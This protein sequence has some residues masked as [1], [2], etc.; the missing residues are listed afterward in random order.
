MSI[1]RAQEFLEREKGMYPDCAEAYKRFEEL[2]QQKLWHQLSVAIG[3]HLRE[4]PRRATHHAGR[5]LDLY[6][7]FVSEFAEKLNPL[8]YVEFAVASVRDMDL[9]E[10]GAVDLALKYLRE[11]V[12]HVKSRSEPDAL[13]ATAVAVAVSGDVCVAGGRLGEARAF[14]DEADATL[15]RVA[16]AHPSVWAQYYRVCAAYRKARN[17]PEEFYR[18][19]L[20]YLSY[21]ALADVPAREQHELARDL[22]LAALVGPATYN[23]GELL[24]SPVCAR[25]RDE[26]GTAWLVPLLAAFNRGDAAEFQRLVAAAQRDPACAAV[27]A[28]LQR[29]EAVLAEKISILALMELVFRQSTTDGGRRIAFADIAR[30]AGIPLDSVETLAVHSMALGLVRGTIDQVDQVFDVQWVQPRVLDKSQLQ[31]MISMLDDWSGRI[32]LA[33]DTLHQQQP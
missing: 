25:L 3:E 20:S 12:E 18:A 29:S 17:E 24:G 5:I 30:Q 6:V 16:G 19:G 21:V 13:S 4:E 2:F 23:I 27:V 22:A 28:A 33:L 32:S 8:S 14:L 15:Q 11:A 26:P 9:Q 1:K 31:T 10:P 7:R